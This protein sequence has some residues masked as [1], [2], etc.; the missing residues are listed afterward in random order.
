MNIPLTC[1]VDATYPAAV[2]PDKPSSSYI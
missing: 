1:E 2:F